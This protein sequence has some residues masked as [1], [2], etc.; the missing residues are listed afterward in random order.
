LLGHIAVK[1][2][3][4]EAYAIE[5]VVDLDSSFLAL[6]ENEHEEGNAAINDGLEGFFLMVLTLL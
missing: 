1:D 4:I 5:P 6:A 2:I 3:G